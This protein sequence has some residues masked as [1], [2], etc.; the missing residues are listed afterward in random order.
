M[1]QQI[2]YTFAPSHY[3]EKARWGLDAASIPYREVCWAPGPHVLLARRVA[4]RTTVPIL[5][6][7]DSC[8]QGSS[9]IFDWIEAQGRAPWR[10]PESEAARSEICALEAHADSA[11]GVAVRRFAYAIMLSHA[12][13]MAAAALFAPVAWRQRLFA[14]VMWPMT[15]RV[16]RRSLRAEASDI[17]SARADVELELEALDV[18]LRDQRTYLVGDHLSRADLTVASLIS[19]VVQPP[20]H[21]V[22]GRE[23][24]GWALERELAA[25]TNRPSV[26]WAR[27][28]YLRHRSPAASGHLDH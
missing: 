6:W 23:P 15:K 14:G 17:A 11:I 25:W 1:T 28:L 18:R 13:R 24:S 21:P 22:Y 7:G 19:P 4:E 27:A 5:S 10:R 12:P 20:E 3:C 8:V 2:L 26:K 9:A 16:L